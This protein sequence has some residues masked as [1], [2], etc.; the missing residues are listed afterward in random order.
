[1]KSKMWPSG[2]QGWA[3]RYQL[4][5]G[6]S[7]VPAAA[8]EKREAELLASVLEAGLPAVE[9]FGDAEELAAEDAAEMAT[10]EEA[11]RSS[12]GGGLQPAV[13]LMGMMLLSL[14]AA[15][16]VLTF[17]RSGWFV[18]VD[19][20]SGVVAATVLLCAVG[21]IAVHGLFVAG[22]SRAAVGALVATAVVT[23][24]GIAVAEGMGPGHTAATDF[25]VLVLGVGCVAPGLILLLVAH[26]LPQPSLRA[27]WDDAE[28]LR[29]FRGG[30][31]A[32]LVPG[33]TARGHVAEIEQAI[34]SGSESAAAE[35][36]HP[37]VLART[38]A[39]DDPVAG[40]RRWWM[41]AIGACAIP[42][43][44]AAMN[45]SS[46]TWGIFSV[47]IAIVLA[48]VGVVMMV[49]KWRQRP[50]RVAR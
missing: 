13:W 19:V 42:L 9:L 30:L 14:G 37:L 29:I 33:V 6:G 41:S 34:G 36:G 11:V 50:T 32:R 43:V 5:M 4:S 22:Q 39:K 35:F 38:L 21:A 3:A 46:R 20:A 31:R 8:L 40:V 15:P 28:W 18:D 16:T 7:D 25:P 48:I 17:I 24:G 26:L 12:E 47:P 45:A 10:V 44:L 1:M 2:D 49:I 27:D 23:V